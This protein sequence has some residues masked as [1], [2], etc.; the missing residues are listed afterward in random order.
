MKKLEPVTKNVSGWRR[1]SAQGSYELNSEVTLGSIDRNNHS[2]LY[3][4]LP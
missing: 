1:G 3:F 4:M 2:I